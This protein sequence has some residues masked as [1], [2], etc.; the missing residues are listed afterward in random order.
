M[1]TV[2]L[3]GPHVIYRSF[4]LPRAESNHHNRARLCDLA[5]PNVLSI[6]LFPKKKF[7]YPQPGLLQ[8]EVII[9]SLVLS[10]LL[11]TSQLILNQD[12]ELYFFKNI[13]FLLRILC[14]HLFFHSSCLTWPS[15]SLLQLPLCLFILEHSWH[16]SQP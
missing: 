4:C 15:S 11:S 13:R 12:A 14:C 8:S 3:T 16:T 9:V 10:P 2:I 6:C 5:K 1:N 7:V